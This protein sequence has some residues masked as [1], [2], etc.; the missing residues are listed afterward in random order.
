MQHVKQLSVALI[1]LGLSAPILAN[2][3][4]C[5][6]SQHGGLK[7]AVNALYLRPHA[8]SN[9]SD[10]EYDWGMYAQVGYLFP[11]TAN[12]L[13]INYTYFHP[14]D[15]DTK[16]GL[17]LDNIDLES[18]Q[19]FTTGAFDVRMFAGIRYGHINYSLNDNTQSLSSKFHGF[20][21]RLGIDTRYQLSNG[22]G[23]DTHINTGL[24]VGTLSSL[25][26]NKGI[27]EKSDVVKQQYESMTTVIPHASTKIGLDYTYPMQGLSK[28]AICLEAGYQTD[29]YF[30]ALKN[31]SNGISD[32]LSTSG[33]YIEVKYYA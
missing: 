21:P 28:S 16:E 4:L 13:T 9:I 12:D 24:V 17:D 18:G 14:R 29:H 15:N 23:L 10:S 19:R 33:P 3:S 8:I 2:N 22:F 30:K 32:D 20:G 26:Q 25:Y 11:A 6:P 27:V 7:V 5:I 1:A 31:V